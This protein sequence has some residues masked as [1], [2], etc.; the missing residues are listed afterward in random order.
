M[1]RLSNTTRGQT[2]PPWTIRLN[3]NAYRD[4]SER[5]RFNISDRFVKTDDLW[6]QY[7]SSPATGLADEQASDTSGETTGDNT[8]QAEPTLSDRIG[9]DK[10]WTNYF[11]TSFAYEYAENST[12]TLGYNNSILE[13][14]ESG[15]D[16]YKY[17]EPWVN[18]SYWFNPQWNTSLS[19]SVYRCTV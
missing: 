1:P 2:T 5:F 7:L 14:D 9:R 4:L 19:Y 16:N 18:M 17:N 10:F 11:S 6:G 8:A 13:Y 12:V 3:F 15:K